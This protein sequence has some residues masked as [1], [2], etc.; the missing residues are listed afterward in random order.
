M[1]AEAS[2]VVNG[3]PGTSRTQF[4]YHWSTLQSLSCVQTNNILQQRSVNLQI[5]LTPQIN[6]NVTTVWT[7]IHTTHKCHNCR[8]E[9]LHHLLCALLRNSAAVSSRKT[10]ERDDIYCGCEASPIVF[11]VTASWLVLT[12]TQNIYFHCHTYITTCHG[13]TV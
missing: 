7:Q 12:R 8:A 3:T 5:Q 11:H 1:T 6:Q 13:R 4:E 9:Y 10:T 2:R